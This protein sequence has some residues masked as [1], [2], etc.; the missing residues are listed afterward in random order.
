MCDC[1]LFRVFH[2]GPLNGSG[3]ISVNFS[4]G[5][6][7]LPT[8]HAN[9]GASGDQSEAKNGK[10]KMQLY[11]FTISMF[12]NWI[13]VQG[14]WMY[15]AWVWLVGE[16][17]GNIKF[18]IQ[19]IHVSPMFG[20]SPSPEAS[21]NVPV[22]ERSLSEAWVGWLDEAVFSAGLAGCWVLLFMFCFSCCGLIFGLIFKPSGPGENVHLLIV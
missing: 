21:R 16:S 19:F 12:V 15:C 20:A 7:P 3:E 9:G 10:G 13:W 8:G 11:K 6:E 22:L 18:S 2:L 17:N 14:D 5:M 1:L 4:V